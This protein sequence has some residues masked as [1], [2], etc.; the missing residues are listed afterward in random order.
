[1]EG[2]IEVR[3]GLE[4]EKPALLRAFSM[5]APGV[6]PGSGSAPPG[7]TTSLSGALYHDSGRPPEGS[8]N[9]YPVLSFA[10]RPDRQSRG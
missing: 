2:E 9:R 10:I 6:E 5:E 3:G 8:S 1:M 4:K 7:P